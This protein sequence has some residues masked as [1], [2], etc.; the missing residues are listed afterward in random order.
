MDKFQS[1]V[2]AAS[3]PE[4]G[5]DRDIMLTNVMLYWLTRTG[6]SAANVYYEDMHSGQWP[7]P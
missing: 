6:G 5:V 1:W 3:L 7:E 4:D 2:C